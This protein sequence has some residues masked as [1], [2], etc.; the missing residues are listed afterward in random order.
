MKKVN[1]F[2]QLLLFLVII[3]VFNT[4]YVVADELPYTLGVEEGNEFIYE[5]TVRD[6]DLIE[7]NSF[8]L[9]TYPVGYHHKWRITYAKESDDF[10]D[11]MLDHWDFTNQPFNEKPDQERII[12]QIVANPQLCETSSTSR[13]IALSISIICAVPVD[14]YLEEL[15]DGCLSDDGFEDSANSL[16]IHYEEGFSLKFIYGSETGFAEVIQFSVGNE[17]FYE[18]TLNEETMDSISGYGVGF[19]STIVIFSTFSLI[20]IIIKKKKVILKSN[21]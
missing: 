14:K 4:R 3:D 21:F 11:L 20:F 9:T 6:T 8:D 5:V 18:T 15:V 7:A 13:D 17:I 16:T 19:I 2:L 12:L 10:H 1:K